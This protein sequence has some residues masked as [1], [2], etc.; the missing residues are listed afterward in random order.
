MDSFKSLSKDMISYAYAIGRTMTGFSRCDVSNL[1]SAPN[2]PVW[3]F[4]W[5]NSL[6]KNFPWKTSLVTWSFIHKKHTES[7][8]V[9]QNSCHFTH[10]QLEEQWLHFHVF[11]VNN[12]CI[13]P[14]SWSAFL[15]ELSR[16]IKSLTKKLAC[17]LKFHLQETR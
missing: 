10:T 9:G 6:Y 16:G 3:L 13:V 15:L 12:L 4:V 11:D 8:L 7:K 17:K 5:I 14:I 2:L 1:S